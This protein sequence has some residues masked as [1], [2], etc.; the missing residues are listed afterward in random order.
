MIVGSWHEFWCAWKRLSDAGRGAP[1]DIWGW[2]PLPRDVPSA[3]RFAAGVL[4]A[5]VT[6]GVASHGARAALARLNALTGDRATRILREDDLAAVG[7]A[8]LGEPAVPAGEGQPSR[9]SARP[10]TD[11]V[12]PPAGR[13]TERKRAADVPRVTVVNLREGS[14]RKR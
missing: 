4:R 1:P 11:G 5:A 8:A 12:S 10:T 6:G 14:P 9:A 7:Y 2:V 13:T 3:A